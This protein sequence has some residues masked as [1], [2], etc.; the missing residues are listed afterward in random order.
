MA[1]AHKV[2]VIIYH[3][4]RTKQPSTDLGARKPILIGMVRILSN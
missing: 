3:I 4:L 2:L 1:L